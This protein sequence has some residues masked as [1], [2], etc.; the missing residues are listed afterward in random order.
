M[1]NR[2]INQPEL[3]VIFYEEF[4][5]LQ[6]QHIFNI[7]YILA[8]YMFLN[9]DM[10]M[11]IYQQEYN[12]KMGLSYL[13]RAAKEKLI[14]EYQYDQFEKTEMKI[15]YYALKAS[16]LLYLKQN[17]IPF[18]KMPPYAAYKEKSRI[19][20]Y[21]QYVIDKGY[22]PNIIIP[23][24]PGLRYFIT[25]QQK[26]CYFPEI[27]SEDTIQGELSRRKIDIEPTFEQIDEPLIEL[28]K[29]TR[30]VNPKNMD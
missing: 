8:K 3:D 5:Q 15:Y 30:A 10:L 12:E 22:E 24:D 21:N 7:I 6:L 9:S 16:T 2:I 13:K 17:Q 29:H 25:K 19:L 1:D 18:L 28:G 23:V 14:I 27:V 4:T 20:T 11:L 26:I